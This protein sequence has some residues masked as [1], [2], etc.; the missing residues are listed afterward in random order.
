MSSEKKSHHT[1]STFQLQPAGYQ[2]SAASILNLNFGTVGRGLAGSSVSST[3][4]ATDLLAASAALPLNGMLAASATGTTVAVSHG[5]FTINLEFDAAAAGAGSAFMAGIE[6]AASQLVTDLNVNNAIAV[7]VSIQYGENNI[8]S[9]S[10]GAS[11]SSAGAYSYTSVRDALTLNAPGATYLSALP[12]GSSFQA[13][14]AMRGRVQNYSNLDVSSA[15]AK[16]LNLISGTSSGVDG[17]ADFGTGL[18]SNVLVGVALHELTH[19]LGR[20]P[21]AGIPNI[22]DLYR[23]TN[24]TGTAERLVDPS[25]PTSTSGYFST[26]GGATALVN[27][28]TASDPSDFRGFSPADPFTEQY[29]PGTTPQTLTALDLQQMDVLGF[30]S[31]CFAEGTCLATPD[32]PVAVEA[33][34]PGMRVLTVAGCARPVRWVGRRRVDLTRHPAPEEVCPIRVRAGAL[35]Q[36]VPPRDLRLSPEH[37][38][39]LDGGLVP[40]RLLVNGS[41]IVRGDRLPVRRLVPC[42][43]GYP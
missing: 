13:Y 21:D 11:A 23:F 38:L 7:N 19:A 17:V 35:G 12:S 3:F 33:L 41:S 30:S 31:A 1:N 36:G 42:R 8:A 9:T 40:A 29:A 28:G 6:N 4:S 37:A 20:V 15:E 32:G 5:N 24:V 14:N 22:F 18:T 26:D 27:Y 43:T 10:A 39:F 34:R 25:S 16:A 2:N